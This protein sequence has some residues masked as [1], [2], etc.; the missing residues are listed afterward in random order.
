VFEYS[1]GSKTSL[2]EKYVKNITRDL[3]MTFEYKKKTECIKCKYEGLEKLYA[4]IEE[5][6]R[7][8]NEMDDDKNFII[9]K[10]RLEL[11]IETAKTVSKK[12]DMLLS[13]LEKGQIT[14]NQFKDLM[15][16]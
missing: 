13:L 1:N 9:E 16:V 11:C 6:N 14:V 8:S 5:H 2:A 15:S 12:T 10:M 7:K 3:G 4:L